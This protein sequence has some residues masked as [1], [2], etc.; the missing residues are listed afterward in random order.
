MDFFATYMHIHLEKNAQH[1]IQSYSE[2]TVVINQLTYQDNLILSRDTLISPW[3]G[4]IE[5]MLTLN[6]EVII[7]G[8]TQANFQLPVPIRIQLSKLNIG[9]ECMNLGA[10]CRTFNVLLSEDRAVVLGILFHP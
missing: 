10:A 1:A 5:S 3:D 2:Q 4:Q 6:P 9:L 7:V 8:H